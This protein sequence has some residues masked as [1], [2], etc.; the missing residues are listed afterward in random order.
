MG[1]F[2]TKHSKAVRLHA[3][4]LALSLSCV[5][6][7]AGGSA[8]A[9]SEENRAEN[10]LEEVVVT[11]QR[12]EESLKDVPIS[13]SAVTGEQLTTGGVM[14]MLD[15]SF[16]VPGLAVAETGPGRQIIVIRG[17]GSER[18]SS[19]LTGVYLDE[20]P[21]SGIQDGFIQSYIDLRTIDLE[22]A[23]VL[24][25]PQGTLFGEGSVGG[26]VRF[27]TKDPVLGEYNGRLAATLY[28]TTDGQES[29]EV[30]GVVNMPVGDA[31][32]VRVAGTYENK[33]GWIDQPSRGLKD[34][35]DNEVYNVRVKTLWAPTEALDVRG[36]IVVHRNEGGGSNIV[37]QSPRDESIFLQ[38]LGWNGTAFDRNA[39]SAFEDEYELYNL[40]ATYNFGDAELLSSTS[41]AKL[42]SL[43]SLTQL[44]GALPTPALE[45]LMRDYRQDAAVLSQEFRLT[46]TGGGP[47]F[48]TV[49]GFI[50]DSELT[51][52]WQSGFDF[53]AP[54]LGAAAFG[55]QAGLEPTSESQSWATFADVSYAITERFKVGGGVRYFFDE[56]KAFDE[57]DRE[58]TLLEDDF[59]AVT[60]RVYASFA[61]TDDVNVYASVGDGFRSGGFNPPTDIARGA[62]ASY[63]PETV[64]SYEAGLKSFLFDRR[65]S[66]DTAVFFSTYE[67][68]QADTATTSS[69]DNEYLQ[70]TANGQRAE[71]R[72]FEWD[73]SWRPTGDLILSFGGDL[74]DTEI[75][76][77]ATAS[78]YN[79]GDPIDFAPEYRLTTSANYEFDWTPTLPGYV[80]LDFNRQ[81]KS[82]STQRRN[83]LGVPEQNVAAPVDFLNLIAGLNFEGWELALFGRNLLDER[84]AVRAG[85]TGLHPQARP[86]TAGV[87]MAKRF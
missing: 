19:S 79:V 54:S 87:T 83:V 30:I 34:I 57:T 70:F 33:G 46:S 15:L 71:L 62:P 22:R 72:G 80:R 58:A 77:A 21:V 50:K 25:G 69:L 40:T 81:G 31:F 44:Y 17:L 48:W 18:G 27:I 56:R 8:H 59:D 68:M 5:G 38:A 28:S 84:G 76:K 10:D 12:R 16:S 55:G 13:I 4:G 51:K 3:G 20:M 11:A 32:A 35:N 63:D 47:F 52:E 42:D 2:L 78:P 49:G 43:A 74:T 7:C 86:R 24:K 45:V 6:W 26:T 41:Y 75:T 29:E 53:N 66:F 82:F 39:T 61:L 73:L 23:E 9:A 60:Y 67:D 36:M 85:W 1:K 64:T 14:N 65:V 37:N